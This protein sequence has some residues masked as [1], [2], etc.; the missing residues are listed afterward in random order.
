[1][2][3]ITLALGGEESI[4]AL[5]NREPPAAQC[6]RQQRS[7]SYHRHFAGREICA[8]LSPMFDE[9]LSPQIVAPSH[10]HKTAA[11][12]LVLLLVLGIYFFYLPG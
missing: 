4:V 1:M 2:C 7:S 6:P 10:R 9:F 8:M 12:F 3:S 5:E 11:L